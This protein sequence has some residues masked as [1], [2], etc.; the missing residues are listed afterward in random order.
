MLQEIT[1][2]TIAPLTD[3]SGAGTP[4]LATTA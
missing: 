3:S 4:E 2:D 1:V